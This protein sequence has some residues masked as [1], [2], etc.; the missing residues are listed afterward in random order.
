MSEQLTLEERL[1]D[2][3]AVNR[4][5]WPVR[6]WR[7]LVDEPGDPLLVGSAFAADENG[8]IDL[9]HTTSQIHDIPHRG[10]LRHQAQRRLD[11]GGRATQYLAMLPQLPFGHFERFYDP[12]ERDIEAVGE[13]FR[14]KES[15]LI[16]A[17]ITPLFTRPAEK[18]ASRAPAVHAPVFED[19]HLLSFGLADEATEETADGP[20]HR[21]IA[22]A[23]VQEMLLR[24][25][26]L[27][28]CHA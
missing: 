11:F 13:A 5:E 22:A 4:Y 9:R 8:G 25:V 6:A 19:V 7:L 23:E 2:G 3:A 1:G 27:S 20:A 12:F 10:A 28:K 24:F 21:C 26:R 18:M 14:L 16:G 15:Q 17:F